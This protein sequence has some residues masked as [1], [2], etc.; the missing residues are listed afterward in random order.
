MTLF[1]RTDLLAD[2]KYQRGRPSTD[3]ESTDAQIY[4]LLTLA[5]QQVASD[6]TA[7]FPR[8]VV[9]AP[10]LM[11]TSDSGA[12]YYVNTTDE[13]SNQ[14]YPFGH[15]EVYASST[16][17]ELFG[18]TYANR[19][20]D[21]VFEGNKIR[22]PGGQT[23]TF[24]SGPYIR[25]AAMPG[26][27]DA[28]TNPT[29]PAVCKPLIVYR[30]LVMWANRGGE[31]DP[32]PYEE[33]YRTAWLG[34]NPQMG[35]VGIQGLIATQYAQSATAATAALQ[36]WRTWVMSLTMARTSFTQVG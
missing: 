1:S 25:Y 7:K 11:A 32:Q 18:S 13:D 15:A 5:Q 24:T 2:F 6:I 23:R 8:F 14:V 12:T 19:E 21:V 35:D 20:G 3:E 9:G 26:T 29:I 4:R 34:A 33:M 16:A 17:G 10:A 22:I 30:A 36:W 31:R 28:S 27:I